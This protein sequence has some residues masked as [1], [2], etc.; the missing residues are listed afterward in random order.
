MLLYPSIYLYVFYSIQ[1][2]ISLSNPVTEFGAGV[3][4]EEK[5]FKDE[6]SELVL[7]FLELA[8]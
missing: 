5:N 7:R 1:R 4:L 2:N 8:I 6:S 3:V